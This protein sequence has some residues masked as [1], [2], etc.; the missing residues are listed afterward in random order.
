[1]NWDN[2]FNDIKKWMEASNVMSQKHS[3]TSEVYWD[4]LIDTLGNL[5]NRYNNHP[6]VLGFLIVL[7]KIQEDS[8]KQVVGG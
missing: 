3:I 1:M 6:V 5:G 2:V 7:I 4:W 8:Y